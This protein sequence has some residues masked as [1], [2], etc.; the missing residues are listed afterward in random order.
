[1]ARIAMLP[2]DEP[3]ASGGYLVNQDLL[4]IMRHRPEAADGLVELV[5]TIL[6]TGTLPKRLLEL[7]RLRVAFH[8]QCRSCMAVRFGAATAE[9]LDDELVCSLE[10]PEE[11]PDLTDAEK[12]ALRFADL[13]ATNHLAIDD[14]VYDDLRQYFDEGELVELGLHCALGV[15]TGRLAATWQVTD[16]V[17]DY[18]REDGV[19]G[20]W[21]G[22]QLVVG[23]P[24]ADRHHG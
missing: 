20:P 3:V 18:L 12:A 7:V 23:G 10:R 21:G 17:P 8:N 4:R 24:A 14:A 13:L 11:A 9:G 5:A 6:S 19:V 2:L 16:H 15:G 1:M 22:E